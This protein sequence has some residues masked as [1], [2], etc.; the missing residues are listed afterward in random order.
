MI[1]KRFDY[2]QQPI[3]EG[4]SAILDYWEAQERISGDP[5]DLRKL[6]DFEIDSPKASKISNSKFDD[7]SNRLRE[8]S[9][10]LDIAKNPRLSGQFPTASDGIDRGNLYEAYVIEGRNLKERKYLV[11]MGRFRTGFVN[12][13]KVIEPNRVYVVKIYGHNNER[14]FYNITTEESGVLVAENR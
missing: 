11:Y 3:V 1:R 4:A 12:N 10:R 8:L 13:S 14:Q 2:P 7:L 9:E 5:S 6:F